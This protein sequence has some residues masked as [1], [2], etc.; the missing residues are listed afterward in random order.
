MNQALLISSILK[1]V[2]LCLLVRYLLPVQLKELKHANG[3]R[4]I[5]RLLLNLTLILALNQVI[6]LEFSLSGYLGRTPLI[7]LNTASIIN[8]ASFFVVV[9][10]LMLVYNRA[11]DHGK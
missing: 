9:V 8:S 5:R 1:V 4:R 2:T 7:D 11:N 10:I 3:V 6:L